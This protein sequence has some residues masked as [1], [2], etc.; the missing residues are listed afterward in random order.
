MKE[1]GLSEEE[2]KSNLDKIAEGAV[3]DAWT[4]TNPREISE[5]EMKRLFE[6]TYY[7]T[8]VNF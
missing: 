7:G 1:F 3:A 6:A 8:E 5:D 4:G 2:F